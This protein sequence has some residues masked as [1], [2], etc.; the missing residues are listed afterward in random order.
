M[1]RSAC[2]PRVGC[3]IGQGVSMILSFE[4]SPEFGMRSMLVRSTSGHG[5]GSPPC[6]R[7]GMR[8]GGYRRTACDAWRQRCCRHGRCDR[9]K[10]LPRKNGISDVIPTF[11]MVRRRDPGAIGVWATSRATPAECL[12][13]AVIV[14]PPVE[15]CIVLKGSL[16]K[17]RVIVREFEAERRIGE[18]CWR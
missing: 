3:R 10:H 16:R 7:K 15:K 17:W 4:K 2:K 13:S 12:R 9:L 8:L 6:A 18:T 1:M 14:S 5:E 11:A